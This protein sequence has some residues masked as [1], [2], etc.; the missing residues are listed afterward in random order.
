MQIAKLVALCRKRA[1]LTQE[2]L[3]AKVGITRQHLSQIETGRELS[4]FDTIAALLIECGY[5]LVDCIKPPKEFGDDE[6]GQVLKIVEQAL[7]DERH[8]KIV[9]YVTNLFQLRDVQAGEGSPQP[10]SK[11]R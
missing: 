4:T 1:G 3:A 5:R 6:A 10:P 8:D 9:E 2:D 11:R 7:N